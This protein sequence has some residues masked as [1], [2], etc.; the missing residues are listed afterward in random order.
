MR[1]AKELRLLPL[2][3]VGPD[4]VLSCS[5]V[6]LL[7]LLSHPPCL[8]TR[9]GCSHK[10]ST[11]STVQWEGALRGKGCLL[12]PGPGLPMGSRALSEDSV[13]ARPALSTPP[14][15]WLLTASLL[16]PRG[17]HAHAP[18]TPGL[19]P[20]PPPLLHMLLPFQTSIHKAGY[21]ASACGRPAN[22]ARTHCLRPQSTAPHLVRVF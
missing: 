4:P 6:S 8:P 13:G 22:A 7:C 3:P 1:W 18:R 10:P 16:L 20:P 17:L 2:S 9:H 15:S 14:S 19:S 12:Y 11:V 5:Q 21:P